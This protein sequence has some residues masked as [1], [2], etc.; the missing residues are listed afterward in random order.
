MNLRSVGGSA[1]IAACLAVSVLAT[2]ACGATSTKPLTAAEIAQKTTQSDLKDT[3]FKLTASISASGLNIVFTGN[4]KFTKSPPRAELILHTS[5]L[6]TTVTIDDITAGGYD[7]TKTTPSKTTKYVKTKS[8]SSSGLGVSGGSF[9]DFGSI[10]NPTLVGTETVD[11]YQTYHL[12]G[13]PTTATPTAGS[14]STPGTE[15]LW[16]K[17]DNFYPVKAMLTQTS[18]VSGQTASENL[19]IT[20]TSWNTGLTINVPPANDVVNG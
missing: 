16:V 13:T 4:G 3:A 19:T 12:R 9:T 1:L 7:Y 2:A 6:G 5:L 18:S 17:T 10:G 11:G 14:S 15:D 8:N 20:F